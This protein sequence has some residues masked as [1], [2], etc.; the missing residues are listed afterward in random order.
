ML[1]SNIVEHLQAHLNTQNDALAYF[2]C[3]FRDEKTQQSWN[4]L[5]SIIA[6]IASQNQKSLHDLED[7]YKC[8]DPAAFN[9]ESCESTDLLELVH[10]MAANFVGDVMIVIDGLDEIE[11]SDRDETLELL[12]NLA[13]PPTLIGRGQ[14]NCPQNAPS[15]AACGLS[16]GQLTEP[17]IVPIIGSHEGTSNTLEPIISEDIDGSAQSTT[18]IKS[19]FVS[20]TLP[21]IKMALRDFAEQIIEADK[22]DLTIYVLSE[23]DRYMKKS[24][25]KFSNLALKEQILDGLIGGANGMYVVHQL[26]R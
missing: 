11:H 16:N 9:S 12:H 15:S 21:Y 14:T 20:R 18:R 7:F 13:V 4:I 26:Y 3:D 23:M 25:L 17:V 24:R 5:G 19:L 22:D 1:T 10:R 6:Q 2:Y 8:H